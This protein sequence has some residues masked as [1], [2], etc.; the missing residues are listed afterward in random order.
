[1]KGIQLQLLMG[2]T[3]AVPVPAEVAEALS[4]VEV[5]HQDEGRSGFQLT[6]RVGRATPDSIPDYNI[7]RD[8]LFRPFNR[9]ILIITIN[10]QT[11]VLSDGVITHQQFNPSAQPG[12]STLTLTG[13]DL[14][15]MMDMHEHPQLFP[16]ADDALIALSIITLYSSYGLI[17]EVIPTRESLAPLPTE[18]I[19]CKV[20]TDLEVLTSLAQK[21]GYVFYLRPSSTPH[22]NH[23]Y[24]GPPIRAGLPQRALSFG[25]GADSNVDSLSFDYS[26]L[27]PTLVSGMVMDKSLNTPLPVVT[28]R[29][30]RLELS[31]RPALASQFP[32]VKTRLLEKSDGKTYGEAFWQA[33]AVTDRSVD[34]V[35]TASGELQA[36]RYGDVL[37]ARQLV[38]VRGVGTTHDGLYYVRSVTHSISHGEY[39]QKFSL[40]REGSGSRVKTVRI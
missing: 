34:K 35:V 27:E 30:T 21:H 24:W 33:Q 11:Q 7:F 17:P 26:P 15:V 8:P 9:V 25:A 4:S 38:A 12:A 39:K 6:F 3:I 13:E 14:S 2:T 40:T 36:V 32:N 5:S 29:S 10:G 23:A 28:F 19:P 20:G 16:G 18:S 22:I 1:M 31:S 37:K